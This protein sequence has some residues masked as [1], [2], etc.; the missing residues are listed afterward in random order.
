M[1]KIIPKQRTITTNEIIDTICDKC[2]ISSKEEREKGNEVYFES[3]EIEWGYGSKYDTDKWTWD[4]CESCIEEILKDV[5][6]TKIE[7]FDGF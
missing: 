7:P 3:F 4:L 6:V 2:G 1:K 5:N